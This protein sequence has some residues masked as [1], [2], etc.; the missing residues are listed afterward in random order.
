MVAHPHNAFLGVLLDMG[1][2][3]LITV[4]AFFV[5]TWRNFRKLY[6]DASLSPEMRGL[7][8]GAAAGLV[9][10]VTAGFA[11]SRLTPV[12]E[13]AYLWLAIGIMYGVMA[14]KAKA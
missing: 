12:P 1:I 14:R 4:G 2:V 9:A 3:G 5:L 13:Q 8:Q 6:R 11:G 7:F 10:F